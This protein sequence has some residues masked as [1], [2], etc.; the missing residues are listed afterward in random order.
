M[1][2]LTTMSQD[3]ERFGMNDFIDELVGISEKR[4]VSPIHFENVKKAIE[5]FNSVGVEIDISI[6][7][8]TPY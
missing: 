1:P 4:N 7:L 8:E 3:P 5:A 2:A 6:R